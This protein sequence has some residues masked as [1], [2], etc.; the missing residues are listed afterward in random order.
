VSL[1]QFQRHLGQLFDVVDRLA[2]AHRELTASYAR[3]WSKATGR[4][5]KATPTATS[6]ATST[7]TPTATPTTRSSAESQAAS[8]DHG[9]VP[10]GHNGV[11][12]ASNGHLGTS[13]DNHRAPAG[14]QAASTDPEPA[15]AEVSPESIR[16]RAYELYERRGRQPGD[17]LEDWRRAEAELRAV[18]SRRP[19]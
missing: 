12:V 18:N 8:A 3:I 1:T 2:A 4:S 16:A 13:A 6:T 9:A 17:P 19:G 10:T 11:P 14:S 15:K 7:A 5:S